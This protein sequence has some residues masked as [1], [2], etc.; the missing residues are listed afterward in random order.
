MKRKVE[1]KLRE[2]K[3]I[4]KEI[5]GKDIDV[6]VRYNLNSASVLGYYRHRNLS[7]TLNEK[8]LLEFGDRYINEVFVHEFAHAVVR[9]LYPTGWTKNNKRIMPHGKEFK[10]VCRNFGIVGRAT[11]LT[12]SDSKVL[13]EKREKNKQNRVE[14]RCSCSSH[15]VSK[16]IYNRV[17]A[18]IDYFCTDCGDSLRIPLESKV[19]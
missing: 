8:L 9:A 14:L 16:T 7:I 13:K 12:F 10:E 1:L 19:V 11:T 4:T 15:K 2:L 18:G 17:K 3:R 5:Y 6:T